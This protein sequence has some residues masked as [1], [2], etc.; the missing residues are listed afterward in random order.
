MAVAG[1]TRNELNIEVKQNHLTISAKKVAD[2]N[3]R[4]F[5][6]QGIAA[7]NFERR[8]QLADYVRVE[9]ANL[10]NG[11]LH[12]D[13]VREVPDIMKPRNIEISEGT[14]PSVTSASVIDSKVA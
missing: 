13:L 6:H 7:R 14:Q 8:F 3:A 2:K 5:L 10:E 4:Q 11:L 12:V 1:F 9:N